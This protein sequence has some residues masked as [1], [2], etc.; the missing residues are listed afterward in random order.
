V[1]SGLSIAEIRWLLI[2]QIVMAGLST[3][4][5]AA[6]SPRVLESKAI[7][8]AFSQR[9]G[10][11][12]QPQ[13]QAYPQ[14]R[15]AAVVNDEVISVADLASRIRMVT[16]STAI[17][18]T[19][20]ARQRVAARVL[21]ILVDER[22]KIQEAKRKNITATQEEIDKAVASIA[23]QNNMKPD[24][25]YQ[26]L[27]ASGIER[28]SLISQ[29]TASIVWAKLI[30]QM[31][32]ETDPVSDEEIDAALKRLKQNENTPEARVAEIFLAVDN[33]QQDGDV[34]ALAERLIA[35]MQH[36][37]RFSAVAQQFSQSATAAVGGDIGW[38]HPDELSPPLAKAVAN[39]RP[40]ELSPPIRAAGG[41]YLL[42]V[43]DRRGVGGAPGEDDTM[44][45]IVQVVFPLPAQASE[46]ARRA[47]IARVEAV[48]GEAKTCDELLK[49]GK[50]EAP[51]LSSQGDLRLGQIAPAMRSTVLGLGIGQP[52]QP[53]M[54]K[55]G[56]GVIMVCGKTQAKPVVP[57]REDVAEN[58]MRDRLDMLAQRYLRD[59]RRA[60]FV[61]VRV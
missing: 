49:I 58:L 16:L 54:Q 29:V 34:R 55:N 43:V 53:I 61:D 40:G 6:A 18:D 27:K 20:E 1:V 31:A 47:A 4:I 3:T 30:R 26:V 36:G 7:P 23:Q 44:L 48:R 10:P 35:Q 41:Y 28:N 56:V 24:Q 45:H 25:L 22:L 5:A 46:E 37:T 19:P 8:P 9:R 17:P 15:I 60:A 50:A 33:P 38:V 39:L 11:G 2:L 12:Q 13:E 51:Q 42:L 21:R 14:M 59:L 32:A 52:S 57:T